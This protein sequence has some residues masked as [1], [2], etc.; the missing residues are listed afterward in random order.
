[1]VKISRKKIT[2]IINTSSSS[3]INVEPKK[4]FD[5]KLVAKEILKGNVLVVDINK[6]SKVEAIR[7]I[8]FITGV[9]FTTNGGFKK[10]ANKTYLLAPSKKILKKFLPQF[11]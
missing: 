2:I 11:E 4:F 8:D 3:L 1:M 10:I 7:F 5:S 6:M 9:L